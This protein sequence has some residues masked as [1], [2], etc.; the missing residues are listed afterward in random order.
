[1]KTN[2]FFLILI[3]GSLTALS[4]LSIDMYLSAFPEI[5]K[6]LNTTVAEVSLSLSSYFI[7]LSLGQLFYGPLLDRFGRKPPLY[8]GLLIYIFA[9]I[10]CLYSHSIDALIAFRLLQAV[11]GCAA[12][13]TAMSMVRDLFS[14]KEGA[15]VFSL[16]VLILGVSPLLA[17]TVG[18]YMTAFWGWHSVFIALGSI[19]LI[20][21][22]VAIVF[23]PSSHTP[24]K[25]IKLRFGP[26]FSN[27][28]EILKQPQFYT[29][30]L[31][32]AVAFS[33]LFV[34]VAGSPIIFMNIYK[35]S[36]Q[37][38]GWIF[39]G[40]SVG[41]IGMS[42]M[43]IYFL[44]HFS[45]EQILKA[46]LLVQ[47]TAGIIF[48]TTG[49]INVLNLPL[50]LLL[51]F[52]FLS[53]VGLINPNAAALALAPFTKNVGSAAA[54]MGFL[55]MGIGAIASTIVGL[56][57]SNSMIPTISILAI[58]SCL[59]NIVLSWGRKR[60]RNKVEVNNDIVAGVV[61]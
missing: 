54:L 15:K 11:G 49:T 32:G 16:L 45:N 39:A 17:P 36:A 14:V 1:M 59:A 61:H 18:S 60:I 41:F 20:L 19:A 31:C 7:G 58:S 8:V 27:Y 30:T 23:L 9:S 50:T 42:Q 24:D 5:A 44:K 28:L 26:I 12:N 37:T 25:S 21:L 48:V 56:M 29:Y 46:A 2:N 55:Q 4:P 3:L 13:V 22:L 43:N 6:N 35:V 10:G 33:G 53:C 40:L 51:F 57:S 34:Y 38:Y 52:A 47:A